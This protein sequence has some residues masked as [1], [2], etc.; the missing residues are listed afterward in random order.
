MNA[1]E[2]AY[3]LQGFFE[4]TEDDKQ[5]TKK[6]VKIIRDHLSLVF[7]KVTPDRSAGSDI[8]YCEQRDVLKRIQETM[9]RMEKQPA[10]A[11]PSIPWVQPLTPYQPP[12]EV[13]CSTSTAANP[14]STSVGVNT[15]KP[16]C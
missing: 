11:M 3:W 12:F 13:T 2:F 7:K 10:P 15:N 4:L 9:E 16:V 1:Q 5:L 6:Q 8:P 14:P